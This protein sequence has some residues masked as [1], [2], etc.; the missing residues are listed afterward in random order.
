MSLPQIANSTVAPRVVNMDNL[1][2]SDNKN[3]SLNLIATYGDSES[4][5]DE[6]D[7]DLSAE[8]E[9]HGLSIMVLKNNIINA[10]AHGPL[11]SNQA[12]VSSEVISQPKEIGVCKPQYREV[13]DP[14]SSDSTVSVSESSDSDLDS[15]VD[16][17]KEVEQVLGR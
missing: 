17:V 4:D 16:S 14:T 12:T 1:E 11:S 10:C 7:G 15:D 13:H 8:G 3:M 5:S 9:S 2:G 6:R